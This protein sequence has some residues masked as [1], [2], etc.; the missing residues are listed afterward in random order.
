MRKHTDRDRARAPCAEFPAKVAR[1]PT[2][3]NEDRD[4]AGRYGQN[5]GPVEVFNPN[6]ERNGE[7]PAIMHVAGEHAAPKVAML[8]GL[9]GKPVILRILWNHRP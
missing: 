9:G 3:R 6:Q 5:A 7:V 8:A 2:V 1:E 4:P